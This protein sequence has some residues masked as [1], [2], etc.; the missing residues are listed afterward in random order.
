MRKALLNLVFL[1]AAMAL[2]GCAAQP[3]AE[4]IAALNYGPPISQEWAEAQAK[5]AI[6]S[7]LKDPY[8]AQFQF[9]QVYQGYVTG[10]A[11][12]GHKLS[13]GYLLDV[14]VN[15]RNSY[16][17]YTGYKPYKFLFFNGK[18]VGSWQIS[19]QGLMLSF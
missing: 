1:G 6:S 5:E 16:G 9:G 7:R 19:K 2:A 4:Q 3:T 12:E 13:P 18:L 10:S 17:G 15:A 14:H 8:T 11:I